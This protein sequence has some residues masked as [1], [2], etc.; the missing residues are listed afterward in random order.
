MEERQKKRPDIEH[1]ISTFTSEEVADVANSW[2]DRGDVTGAMQLA[3][4]AARLDTADAG[5]W[6][7]VAGLKR[8]AGDIRGA[9]DAYTTAIDRGYPSFVNRGLCFESV[10]NWNVARGDY[11]AALVLDPIDVD[12][13]VDLGTLELSQGHV[14]EGAL[15]LRAAAALDPQANWQ[16]ADAYLAHNKF[17]D[18]EKALHLA[19][20][21]GEPRAYRD[22]ANLLMDS[23]PP[24]TIEKYFLTAISAGSSLARRDLVI[25]LDQQGEQDRAIE[26][27][28]QGV[29]EGDAE[30]FAPLA[31]IYESRDQY[32]LA[33]HCYRLAIA[34]GE[35]VWQDDLDNLLIEFPA[36]RNT[37]EP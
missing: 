11:L 8:D 17:A 14:A 13:L 28:L 27:A 16:L 5:L 32:A 34:N 20:E 33:V 30:C 24:T 7:Y 36:L 9:I 31:V 6:D 23:S 29:A 18:A 26:F 3:E 37:A 12:A 19:I 21:A 15:R 25:Y 4:A 35:D 10:A 1:I 2:L 22:L